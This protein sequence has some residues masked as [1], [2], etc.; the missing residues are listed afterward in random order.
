MNSNLLLTEKALDALEQIEARGLV[1]GLV[2]NALSD[3]E[4]A[5]ALREVLND[6]RYGALR[7][8]PACNFSTSKDLRQA[9]VELHM[10][11]Q[12]PATPGAPVRWRTRMAEG[13]RLMARL[14]QM[15]PKHDGPTSWAAAP[16]LVADYRFL[17]RPRQYPKRD[18]TSA[19]VME[20]IGDKVSTPGVLDAVRH[21]LDK[22]T[23]TVRLASFQT[24]SAARV[25][26]GLE[27]GIHRATLVSAGTG[28][29]KTLA[30]YLPA[31][32]WLANQRKSTP[33]HGGVRVLALYPRNELL[34]DQ[35]REVFD[36]CR[37]FDD[38][39]SPHGVAPLRVGV[40]FGSVPH[41]ATS[42]F[43]GVQSWPGDARDRTC[44]FFRCPQC[45]GEM[46]LKRADL[47]AGVQRLV[48]RSCGNCVDD[49]QL[50]FTREAMKK[51]PP[52]VLFTSV[53]MLNQS[54]GDNDSRHLFGLGPQAYRTPDLVLLDEVHLYAG[55]FGAQV[56]YLLRR[57]RNLSGG[58]SSFVGLSATITEGQSFFAAL[59]GLDATAVEEISPKPDQ[60]EEEG[61]EY[62][63]ALRGDPVSQTALL[64]AS[65][66]S[67]MLASRLL[68]P[69]DGYNKN[70][71]P[72]CGWRSFAFTD[73]LDAANRLYRDLLDAEGRFPNGAEK[74]TRNGHSPV[75]ANLRRSD[76]SPGRRY[77]AGQDWRIVQDAQHNLAKGQEIART[78]SYDTG[79]SIRSQ[80]VVATAALEVGFDDPDVGVVLQH[81]APRDV[82][83]FLQRK[84]RAGRTRHMRPWTVV[85][86]SDYG[87]DRLA[88]Q[89]YDQLFNPILPPRQLPMSN[90]YVQRM[91][92]VFALFD[93][94]GE[95][96]QNDPTGMSVWRAMGGPGKDTA[97]EGWSEEGFA[98]LK[99]L[100]R[101]ELPSTV[102]GWKSLQ[103]RARKLSPGGPNPWAGANWLQGKLQ[104]RRLLE[105]LVQILRDPD[106]ANAWAAR[107]SSMLGL[108]RDDVELLQWSHPRPV[109]LGAIPTAVRRLATNWRWHETAGGDFSARQPLPDFVP[110]ALFSDLS[111][112][113]LCVTVP[114]RMRHSGAHYMPVQQGLTEF[115]PGRVSM[116]FDDALWLGVDAAELD[117][118]LALGQEVV[119]QDVQVGRW[120]M[121]HPQA[122]FRHSEAPTGEGYAAFTPVTSHLMSASPMRTGS[123]TGAP[124]QVGRTSNA[125]LH[126]A[127]HL[128][129]P[130][131]GTDLQPPV[132]IGIASLFSRVQACTHAGQS[133]A[134]VRRYAVGSRA[135]LRLEK[136]RDRHA[137]T[138]EWR[139]MNGAEPCAIGFDIDT[140]ALI[141]SLNLPTE[142]HSTIDWSD[143]RRTRAARSARF[144][145]EAQHGTGLMA[146]VGNPFLRIWLCQIFETAA[147]LVAGERGDLSA[148]LDALAAGHEHDVLRQVLHTVFQAPEEDASESAEDKSDKLRQALDAEL[149]DPVVLQALRATSGVLIDPM[150]PD[151]NAWLSMVV[152]T[153]LGAAIL[154][155][156]QQACPQID[157]DSLVVDI[158]PGPGADGVSPAGR[159]IWVSEVNPGGNGLIEQVVD[160][161]AT[162]PEALYHHIEAALSESEFEVTERQLRETLQLLSGG[163]EGEDVR[164]AFAAVR[165]AMSSAQ[166]RNRFADLRVM[167][168]QKGQA[169]FHSYAVALSLRLLRHGS[170]PELDALLSRV[171]DTWDALE[172][173]HGI[174]VDLR[175]VCAQFSNDKRLDDALLAAQFDLPSGDRRAWRFSVLQGILWARG[176]ALRGVVLPLPNRYS[177]AAAVSER[178]LLGQWLTPREVP[179]DPGHPGWQKV[180]RE[181]LVQRSRATVAVP[182]A[183]AA[184]WLP[185]VVREV[186]TEPVQFA[187]LNVYARLRAVKRVNGQIEWTFEIPESV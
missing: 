84:G 173:H 147:L 148:A 172:A 129:M 164:E 181:R 29:G 122:K 34:K 161:M 55:T 94:L 45:T 185:V 187:Y 102:P 149:R 155:A 174:E 180:L 162:H 77:Q 4:V 33:H 39:L 141:F 117:V 22:V 116:R 51:A 169:V 3:E 15:F 166:A 93:H 88:Y 2:D 105:E 104:R 135:G 13:M 110:A 128:Q 37:R 112:P 152:R 108:P 85:V 11:F 96:T 72:F 138:V 127:S 63:L 82:A 1:W 21:W 157:G 49:R 25:L 7:A 171:L 18:Q 178:L 137:L 151:W 40:L 87:R 111:L 107:L 48:C 167:L 114:E 81:K 76:G 143:E 52:D 36:Q 71:H 179:I 12:V 133:A 91:Q 92:A 140:D 59:T 124:W 10:L 80:I 26:G 126:W 130:K 56:G 9:L 69:R 5:A 19:Q 145:W 177:D 139:F 67:L 24:E 159:E 100:A 115:A 132:T 183:H 6:P 41:K 58:R 109:M 168:V 47:E 75:L 64:S 150:G 184:K 17:W 123:V 170:P 62:M 8:D 38:F 54:L 119:E 23:G 60:M 89:A 160:L 28:S 142:L 27:S 182:A 95:R 14:R 176:H 156:I 57:W 74:P 43:S 154:E 83:Q 103:S 121:L 146:A 30:F 68:Q 118:L 50:A 44:P 186:V 97:P 66:Q 31:L 65:I 175:L 20:T 113:E 165:T 32:S 35:L 46:L 136:G 98:E 153:T 61:A 131:R 134:L 86:L 78:T 90:R 73:Q 125:R 106:V 70:N 99:A 53:E 16:A 79:V 163:N 120:Y 101:E 158:D 144:N 42:A